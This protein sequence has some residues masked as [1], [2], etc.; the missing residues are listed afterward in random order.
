M[1]NTFEIEQLKAALNK[2]LSLCQDKKLYYLSRDIERV[3]ADIEWMEEKG[4]FPS[5]FKSIEEI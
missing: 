1:M 2:L 5:D 4:E 3:I